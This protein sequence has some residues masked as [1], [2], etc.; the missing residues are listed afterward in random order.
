M[1]ECTLANGFLN[2]NTWFHAEADDMESTAGPNRDSS[3]DFGADYTYGETAY[4]PSRLM[5]EKQ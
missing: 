5:Y 4:F 1:Y 2:F 3:G